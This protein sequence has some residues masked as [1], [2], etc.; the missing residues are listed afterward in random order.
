MYDNVETDSMIEQVIPFGS[1]A[2]V[3][4]LWE[5]SKGEFVYSF[6]ESVHPIMPQKK[7]PHELGLGN[8]FHSTLN[9]RL[10]F[11]SKIH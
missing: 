10:K 2:V 8:F 6:S 9:F 1:L 3:E 7:N 11:G 5:K 4:N